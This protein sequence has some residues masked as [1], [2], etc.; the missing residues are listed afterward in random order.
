M[1]I[2]FVVYQYKGGVHMPSIL[3]RLLVASV[4]FLGIQ[5]GLAVANDQE[6]TF[7]FY[8]AEDCPPCMAFKRSGLPVVQ[9]SAQENGYLVSVNIIEKTRDVPKPGSYGKADDLLR[10]AAS[11]LKRVYPP[12]FFVTKGDEVVVVYEG[13][14]ESALARAEKDAGK[15]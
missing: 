13:D 9:K 11:E 7:H 14:W 8:G 5:T 3:T 12:I 2:L 1:D 10:K 4:L 15:S 6:I